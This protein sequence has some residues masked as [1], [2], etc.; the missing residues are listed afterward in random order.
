M[1]SK[2]DTT[3]QRFTYELSEYENDVNIHYWRTYKVTKVKLKRKQNSMN[4]YLI[5]KPITFLERTHN[6][7]TL[8][9]IRLTCRSHINGKYRM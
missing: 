4:H 5:P 1:L 8:I 2:T 3:I 9:T 7:A 6:H